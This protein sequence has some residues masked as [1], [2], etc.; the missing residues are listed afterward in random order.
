V[1]AV[2]HVNI[3]KVLLLISHLFFYLMSNHE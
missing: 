3:H 1:D 2:A